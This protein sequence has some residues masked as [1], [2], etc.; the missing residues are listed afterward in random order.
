MMDQSKVSPNASQ[1]ITIQA[2]KVVNGNIVNL[3]KFTL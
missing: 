3:N 1:P 2:S